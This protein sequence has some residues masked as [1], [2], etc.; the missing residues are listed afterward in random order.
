MK[1]NLP[2]TQATTIRYGSLS[3]DTHR[4]NSGN[5][6]TGF[7]MHPLGMVYVYHQNNYCM[8]RTSCNGFEYSRHWS[9]NLT[10]RQVSNKCRKLLLDIQ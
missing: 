2:L 9:A 3:L 7:Y 5:Y 1:K 10:P 6:S 4:V 8:I